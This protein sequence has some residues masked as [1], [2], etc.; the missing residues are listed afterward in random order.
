MFFRAHKF[1]IILKTKFFEA[2]NLQEI[3]CCHEN[4]EH[5]FLTSYQAAEKVQN[6]FYHQHEISDR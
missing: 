3:A 4:R 1:L 6:N 5:F 2:S